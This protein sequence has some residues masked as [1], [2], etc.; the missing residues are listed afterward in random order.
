M[1]LNKKS[2]D[3]SYKILA[4]LRV[5]DYNA[6]IADIRMI[7]LSAFVEVYTKGRHDECSSEQWDIATQINY[8]DTDA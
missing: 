6:H 7:L 2:L 8:V 5:K 1:T 4:N 3:F